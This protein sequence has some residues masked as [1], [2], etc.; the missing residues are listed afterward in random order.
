MKSSSCKI[1]FFDPLVGEIQHE[2]LGEVQLPEVT[3]EF[4]VNQVIY[5]DQK[6]SKE[7]VVNFKNDQLVNALKVHE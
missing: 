5:V 6:V 1:I 2:I 3:S 7:F 4:K